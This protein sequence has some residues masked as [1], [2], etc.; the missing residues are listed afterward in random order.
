MRPSLRW[1]SC[2]RASR[3]SMRYIGS[4]TGI[5]F[6]NAQL[7]YL[8]RPSAQTIHAVALASAVFG[9]CISAPFATLRYKRRAR[10]CSHNGDR[11][12]GRRCRSSGTMRR[13]VG[14]DASPLRL[15]IVAG[16]VGVSGFAPP[17][18]PPRTAPHFDAH[19]M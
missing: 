11:S 3:I 12:K 19:R 16:R 18:M 6:N 14:P 5:V 17:V 4:D 15:G 13:H 9:A 1:V 7:A 8:S 10:C 2:P